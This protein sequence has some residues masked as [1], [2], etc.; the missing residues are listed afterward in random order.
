V[1]L[2][3]VANA[4]GGGDF[5][6]HFPQ[7][8]HKASRFSHGDRPEG[9]CCAAGENLDCCRLGEAPAE[10]NIAEIGCWVALRSTQPRRL[11][12]TAMSTALLYKS[13]IPG[14]LKNPGIFLCHVNLSLPP[15]GG[16]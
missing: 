11:R 13:Q 14:F 2:V 5:F 9:D 8:F 1:K 15:G 16:S 7:V 6:R 4:I 3:P 12:G 10:P